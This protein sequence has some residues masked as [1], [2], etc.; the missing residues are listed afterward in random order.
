MRVE[1]TAQAVAAA[2]K[3]LAL[4]TLPEW[5]LGDLYPGRDSPELARDL[6]LLADDAVAFRRQYEGRLAG[7]PGALGAAVVGCPA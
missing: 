4:G 5:D 1:A 2:D 7:L 3:K 6:V